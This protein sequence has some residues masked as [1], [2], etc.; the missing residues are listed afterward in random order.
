MLVTSS[1]SQRPSYGSWL[2][3]G[4]YLHAICSEFEPWHLLDTTLCDKV[5]P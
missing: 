4:H 1:S 2:T 3:H 5:C